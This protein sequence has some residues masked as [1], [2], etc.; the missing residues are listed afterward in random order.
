MVAQKSF[1]EIDDIQE[2]EPTN[3]LIN[4]S[5]E[6]VF[7]GDFSDWKLYSF[8]RPSLRISADQG[9]KID[10]KHSLKVE[11]FELN[12]TSLS[13]VVY[14][15][16]DQ[17]YLLSAW[18]KA[19]GVRAEKSNGIQIRISGP[20]YI[21][22]KRFEDLLGDSDWTEQKITFTVRGK[23]DDYVPVKVECSF[24]YYGDCAIGTAWFDKIVL[25]KVNEESSPN[26]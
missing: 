3:L 21:I 10:G 9:I 23:S 14:L 25:K 1:R 2:E 20:V 26:L 22:E 8:K 18:V 12:H 24:G 13:Q 4:G 15:R 17:R 19:K 5:F 6:K 16:P 11:H 7:L